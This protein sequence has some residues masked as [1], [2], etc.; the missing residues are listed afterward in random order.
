MLVVGSVTA[1]GCNA[2]VQARVAANKA[3]LAG[4]GFG[5][6][7]ATL[8]QQLDTAPLETNHA[9]VVA[10]ARKLAQQA[11]V[12]RAKRQLDAS[13][14]LLDARRRARRQQEKRLRATLEALT[15]DEVAAAKQV[16]DALRTLQDVQEQ[17]YGAA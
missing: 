8:Q 14:R 3:Y 7:T 5:P 9:A 2:F 6:P 11:A 16:T 17:A 15:A 1:I 10:A 13:Q 4:L 12:Q